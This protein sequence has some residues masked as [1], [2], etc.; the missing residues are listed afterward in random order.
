MLAAFVRRRKT[1]TEQ[2]IEDR[3]TE[4][5]ENSLKD[6]YQEGKYKM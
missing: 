4:R 5:R 2:K 3:S 6:E 1:T